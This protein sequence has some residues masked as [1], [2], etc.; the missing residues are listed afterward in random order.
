M[1]V[2]V[3]HISYKIFT[4]L[5]Y[6]YKR[7]YFNDWIDINRLYKSFNFIH[8][9]VSKKYFFFNMIFFKE[10]AF[11]II[12]KNLVLAYLRLYNKTLFVKVDQEF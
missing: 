6:K 7:N 3:L 12:W 4:S 2:H 11:S 10:S 9:L 1:V 5:M 8:K